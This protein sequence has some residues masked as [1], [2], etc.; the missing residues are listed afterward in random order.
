[1]V[2]SVEFNEYIRPACLPETYE[3]GTQN[4]IA[5]GWGRT[6]VN[7]KQSD[8]LMKVILEL[9]S[10]TE[11]RNGFLLESRKNQLRDGIAV[12]SQFCAGSRT[13]RKDV[14]QVSFIFFAFKRFVSQL[15]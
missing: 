15:E 4:G 12:E 3:T 14:C 13:E 11:C 6:E 1:M 2:R 10:D 5:T 7:S 8:I 9:Y